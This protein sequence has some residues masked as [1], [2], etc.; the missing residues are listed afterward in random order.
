MSERAAR[1]AVAQ[2]ARDR[3]PKAGIQVAPVVGAAPGRGRGG[4]RRT[5]GR[6]PGGRVG[7]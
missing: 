5:P 2:A 4:G 1:Q 6:P 7:F 3:S